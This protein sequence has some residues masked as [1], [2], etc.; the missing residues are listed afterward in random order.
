MVTARNAVLSTSLGLRWQ[1]PRYRRGLT[2]SSSSVVESR[3]NRYLVELGRTPR[4]LLTARPRYL[5][6]FRYAD[7]H[8]LC[9]AHSENVPRF[10]IFRRATYVARVWMVM[11]PRRIN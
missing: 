7:R 9:R 6:R 11:G 2:P 1:P 3:S 4:P 8:F 10:W 5:C